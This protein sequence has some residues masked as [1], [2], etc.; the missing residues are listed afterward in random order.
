MTGE[1]PISED[2]LQALVDDV[3]DEDR[4]EAVRRYLDSHPDEARRIATYRHEG[5]ALRSALSGFAESP[6]PPEMNLETLVEGRRRR[7]AG[8]RQI[9]AAAAVLCIG[10]LTGWFGHG[11]FSTP[12]RGVH[13]L[14]REAADNYGVYAADLRRPVELTPDQRAT[15]V[16]WVSERLGE[17]VEAPDLEA[18]G[19][20][21][22]GGR[23][24]TTPNGPAALFIYEGPTTDRLAVMTRPMAI[25]KNKPMVEQSFGTLEGAT[26]S[27]NGLGFSVVAPRAS[28]QARA[29]A[30]EVRRQ[31]SA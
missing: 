31:T 22:L 19:Y 16:H 30:R 23:L 17:P 11:A 27:R 29:I 6:L 12:P 8:R 5:E 18:A 3:L 4:R 2:D 25:D 14:A 21:F 24:V 26:W 15:L 10:S 7:M 9:A 1:R 28:G 13:A 20:R